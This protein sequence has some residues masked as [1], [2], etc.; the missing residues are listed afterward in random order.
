MVWRLVSCSARK[1]I[2]SRR[3]VTVVTKPVSM[4]C[5]MRPLIMLFVWCHCVLF[6]AFRSFKQ[7]SGLRPQG[8]SINKV[9]TRI[10]IVM[11]IVMSQTQLPASQTCDI[12]VIKPWEYFYRWIS[13]TEIAVLSSEN[14]WISLIKTSL[15]PVTIAAVACMAAHWKQCKRE[16]RG[17]RMCALP[18]QWRQWRCWVPWT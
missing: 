11:V 13:R 14:R 15:L 6:L 5:W 8:L 12:V 9:H 2:N 17:G 1:N 3:A 4:V 18:M 7:A 16:R 10:N